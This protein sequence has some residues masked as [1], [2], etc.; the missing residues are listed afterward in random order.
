MT[1]PSTGIAMRLLIS[2]IRH[3]VPFNVPQAT[4]CLGPCEGC[5]KKL[6]EYLDDQLCDWQGKLEQGITPNLGEIQT[7]AKRARKIRQVLVKNGFI[8][9]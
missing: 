4:L 3:Q 1:K 5:S 2:E 8:N 6:I 7:L 9:E